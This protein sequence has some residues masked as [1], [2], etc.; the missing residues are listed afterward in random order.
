MGRQFIIIFKFYSSICKLKFSTYTYTPNFHRVFKTIRLQ[1]WLVSKHEEKN[2]L[3]L[4]TIYRAWKGGSV[5]IS[6][7]HY[8]LDRDCIRGHTSVQVPETLSMT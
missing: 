2:S 3:L 8:P 7:Q 1:L 6:K 4:Q 5:L